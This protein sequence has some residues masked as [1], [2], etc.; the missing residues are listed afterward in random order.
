MSKGSKPLEN[1]KRDL[2][3]PRPAPPQFKLPVSPREASNGNGSHAVLS[4][5]NPPGAT[6]QHLGV[7]AVPP[8]AVHS[9]DSRPA[10]LILGVYL[11]DKPNHVESLVA[12][13][14]ASTSY[15]VRQRWAALGPVSSDPNVRQVT[16]V[17]STEPAPKFVLIN[18]LLASEPFLSY[19][20]V[21]VTDDDIQLPHG[22]LDDFLAA[23]T[24]LGFRLAQPAR[25]HNSH[26]DHPI[27]E[28]VDENL[29][30]QTLF[31][32]SGPVLS[33]HRSLF[34]LVFPFD[35]ISPMGWG[36]ENV[37]AH[38]LSEQG[39]P[40]GIIDA[41]PVEHTLRPTG[42]FYDRSESRQ[43]Q[44][45]LHHARP[46]LPFD[47]CYSILRN[48]KDISLRASAPLPQRHQE[49][50]PR[51]GVNVSG[52]FASEKGIGEAVRADVRALAAAEIPFVLNNFT[53]PASLNQESEYE[54]F[55]SRNPH[56]INLIHIS[57]DTVPRFTNC[58]G[59]QYF[60]NRFNIGFWAWELSQFPRDWQE[61]FQHLQEVWV[62]S[63]FVRA[64]LAKTSA[65]PVRTVPHCINPPAVPSGAS[66]DRFGFSSDSFIFLFAFDFESCVERKNPDAIIRAFKAAFSASDNVRL[67]LKCSHSQHS[68]EDFEKL[69]QAS[70]GARIDIMDAVLTRLDMNALMSLADCYVSLHRS[71]GFGLTL[72]EAMSLG[73][74]VI[75][76]Q[77]SGNLDFMSADNSFLVPYELVEIQENYGYYSKGC[78]WA[79]PHI[80]RAA[81]MMRHVFEDRDAA[82]AI[83]EKARQH[84]LDKLHPRA[85][86]TLMKEHL[87]RIM[88]GQ[89][90]RRDASVDGHSPMIPA[91]PTS[92]TLS[93][94]RSPGRSAGRSASECSIIVPVYNNSALTRGC[95]DAVLSLPRESAR[96]EIIVV[97]DASTDA[98]AE[99]LA[100]YRSTIRVVR[101]A[102]NSGFAKS[103]NDGAA[104]ANGE[105]LVFLNNDTVPRQGWLD[106]LVVYARKHP[107]AAIIGSKLLFPNHTIQHAGVIVGRNYYPRHI[108]VGFPSDHPAVNVSRRFQAVTGACMLVRTDLFR[109]LGGF[110]QAFVNG[111]ED[112]DFCFR[113]GRLGWEI[114]YCHESVL[115]HLQSATRV[116][117]Y[118]EEERNCSVYYT[119]WARRVEPDDVHYD[120]NNNPVAMAGDLFSVR[121]HVNKAIRSNGEDSF[122]TAVAPRRAPPLT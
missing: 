56:P 5:Q 18:Q 58:I 19:E 115:I 83:G 59:K 51:L 69:K 78:Y 62:P 61:R 35:L 107:K 45:R 6:V 57:A 15:R 16:S 73:K 96:H 85:V 90:S 30:R 64:S 120:A 77:Y 12:G 102:T 24:A 116:G 28:C 92:A 71:E 88:Q 93:D 11:G 100:H 76:T 119:R 74:P 44:E 27:V 37:W 86:G 117:R 68:P 72:A 22:F 38:Q 26:I 99:V 10:V 33:F 47:R 20:Y 46:H 34:P 29:A 39:F 9:E 14:A 8:R 7:P 113:A 67:V 122:P 36:Y 109:E 118:K 66:R 81:E 55:S 54:N 112:I 110:D 3:L 25:T 32:E 114:H 52:Y 31:V 41:F 70:A 63:E 23:Q 60:S 13:F 105:F 95:L 84:V 101:H 21:I 91:P 75:A 79:D 43:A 103:C 111:F 121:G 17:H 2:H 98:T 104:A 42:S 80:G 94:P 50:L 1:D 108:Y 89:V 49:S 40:M 82:R 65:I 48:L 97:D 53:D 87:L 106:R 4:S